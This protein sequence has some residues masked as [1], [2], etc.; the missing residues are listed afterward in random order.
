M[1]INKIAELPV[2]AVIDIIGII[3]DSGTYQ[4]VSIKQGKEM[5][6][7]R[8]IQIYDDTLTGI[9]MTLWGEVANKDYP[10]NLIVLIKSARTNEFNA[11]RNLSSSFQTSIFTEEYDNEEYQ[12]MDQW[13]KSMNP[14]DLEI[15]IKDR[16][17]KKIYRLK[18][19]AQLE[20]DSNHLTDPANDK[21]F[22]D[23]RAYILHVK[24][25][26]RVPL[27]YLACTNEKCSKKVIED[28]EGW[29]CVSC[30]T[31]FK[32]VILMNFHRFL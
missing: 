18:S 15:N 5:K 11:T 17:D 32:E 12:K 2:G 22:T 31:T 10:K 8:I 23:C 4:E 26:E 21:I 6:G 7:R 3:K 28:S 24:N 25:D 30:N 29:R 16:P 14:E 20:A 13:R 19:L 9:E 27:Y 1:K